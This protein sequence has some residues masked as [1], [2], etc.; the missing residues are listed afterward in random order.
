MIKYI[1]KLNK[2]IIWFSVGLAFL[3][4]VGLVQL[5]KA[6]GASLYLSPQTG[7]FFVGSTLIFRYS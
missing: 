5:V 1:K 7:T 2:I 4:S 6:E 3:F